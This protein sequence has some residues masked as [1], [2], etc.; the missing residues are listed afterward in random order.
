M[1]MEQALR[2]VKEIGQK[3]VADV[4]DVHQHDYQIIIN[5]IKRVTSYESW[6]KYTKGI[7]EG[8]ELQLQ[9]PKFM[10]R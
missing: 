5:D 10:Q 7:D 2:N 6:E 4:H 9:D 1:K 8:C 3:E